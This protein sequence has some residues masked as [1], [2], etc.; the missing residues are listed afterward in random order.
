MFEKKLQP[1]TSVRLG[2]KEISC[3]CSLFEEVLYLKGIQKCS[4][5][6][7]Q[8]LQV[9]FIEKNTSRVNR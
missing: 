4:Y 2:L 8:L 9:Q 6:L 5:R 7:V 1:E 3:Q